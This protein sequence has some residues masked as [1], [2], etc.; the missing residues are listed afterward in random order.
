M[1]AQVHM[2]YFQSRIKR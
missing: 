1:F 2:T